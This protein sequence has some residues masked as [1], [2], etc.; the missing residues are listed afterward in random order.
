MKKAFVI[1]ALALFASAAFAQTTKKTLELPD[2]KGIYVNSN[3]TVYLKQTNKQEV[4]VEALTEVYSLT[5]IKVEN[6]V[7]QINMERKPENPNKSLWAKIDDI[8]LN[9][10]MKVYVSVKNLND[11]QVNGGGKVISENSIAADYITLAVNGNG[12]MD[13]DIKGNTVKAEVSGSGTLTLKG[14][15]TSIDALVSGTGA[16]KGFS[17]PLETAKAKVS[18]SGTCELNVANNIDATILGSGSVKHKG[19]TKTAVKKIYGSGT[20]D[21]AY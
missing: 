4:T 18:G 14:Y 11:L 21:R 2:F 5:E 8:K 9:P 19:N 20:V 15:A 6:G 1:C 3:Y 16:L 7:L 13:V 12:S 10:T 17:C